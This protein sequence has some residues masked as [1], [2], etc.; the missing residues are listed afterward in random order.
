MNTYISVVKLQMT[1]TSTTTTKV[2]V[3]AMDAYKAKLQLEAMYG[4]GNVVSAPILV[5][6]GGYDLLDYLHCPLKI[7]FVSAVPQNDL[8]FVL[9]NSLT[10]IN[11]THIFGGFEVTIAL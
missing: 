6:W 10:K 1:T 8:I 9:W 4:R 11:L 5:R 7:V 3:Q 2:L